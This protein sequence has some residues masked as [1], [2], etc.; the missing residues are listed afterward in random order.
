MHV[1]E[2]E[3]AEVPKVGERR[4]VITREI[5]L[6]KVKTERQCRDVEVEGSMENEQFEALGLGDQIRQF[7]RLAL[8]VVGLHYSEYYITVNKNRA[9]LLMKEDGYTTIKYKIAPFS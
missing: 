5:Q 7:H 1:N 4:Q 8:I 2:S 6:N 3:V 9:L